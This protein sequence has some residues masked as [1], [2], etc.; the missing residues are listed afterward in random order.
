MV[1]IDRK[2]QT[3]TIFNVM[4]STTKPMAEPVAEP[5]AA[6]GRPARGDVVEGIIAGFRSALREI[7]CL[8]SEQLVRQGVSVTQLHLLSLI[9]RHGEMTM[10][11]VAQVL[12]VSLS[13]ATGIVDRMEERGLVERHR[14]PD[15]RRVVLVRVSE[16]GRRLLGEVEVLKD[17]L[18]AAVL[19]RLTPGQLDR[20][21][22]ALTDLR[23]AVDAVVLERPEYRDHARS[24]ANL[25]AQ[26]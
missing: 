12:D 3:A 5:S 2:V 18:L 20:L 26:R 23:S 19:D 15:D 16:R 10:S 7:R 24:H 14:V 6:T 9:D 25:P 11:R 21:V 22:R 8:G 1:A 17:D 4:R 13:N